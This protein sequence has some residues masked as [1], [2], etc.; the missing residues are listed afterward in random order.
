MI[1]LDLL[2]VSI[3]MV[4]TAM[5]ALGA[6]PATLANTLIILIPNSS[7][8]GLVGK[9]QAAADHTKNA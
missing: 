2:G 1:T 4:D 9:Q 6:D 7:K 5:Y 8:D 3:V